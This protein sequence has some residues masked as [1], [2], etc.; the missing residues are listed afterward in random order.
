MQAEYIICS[1]LEQLSLQA[2]RHCLQL[3]QQCVARH[4]AFHI[5][6]A[7]GSTPK[8]LYQT[9]SQ[10]PFLQ[11]MPWSQTQVFFGDERSV[12]STHPDS[13]VAMAQATLL[14]K[15]PIP[16]QNIHRLHGELSGIRQ[17]ARAYEHCLQQHL[18]STA[19]GI[20]QLD[21]ILLG[22]GEDGHTAS[23]FPNTC[24]LHENSRWVAVNFV[25]Q[26]NTWRI[27]FTFPLINSATHIAVLVAGAA[28]QKR[29]QEIFS[30]EQLVY[31]IQQ[32]KA[33]TQTLWF[34]DRA[35]AAGLSA[36]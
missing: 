13:N 11:Q 32:V 30:S 31:P 27:S 7:G 24:L 9:L 33:R 19:Q 18:P 35:A 8:R 6:L 5:A 10:A 29:V 1:D 26:L 2:A 21:L 22:M 3:A 20:P 16:E 15:V 12:A 14:S 23:L 34:L 25:P 4:G 17:S 28:K 36:S